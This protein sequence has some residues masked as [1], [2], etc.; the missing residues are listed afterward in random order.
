[1]KLPSKTPKATRGGIVDIWNAFMLVGAS[2]DVHDIP[3]SPTTAKRMPRKLISWPEAKRLHKRA[4]RH[5]DKEY[6]IRAFVHFYVGDVKFDGARSGIWLFPW[7]AYEVIRH[8][9]GIITPDFS[10]CQ[11]FPESLKTLAVYRM[12]TFGYWIGSMG[13]EV[14]NN[15][16]WGTV[17]TWDYC[18]AG[19]ERHTVVSVGTVASGLRERRNRPLFTD[20][21][22]EMVR[23]LKPTAIIVYGSSGCKCFD[24]VSA[25]GIE[26]CQFDS[27]T[28]VAFAKGAGHE[29][30]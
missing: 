18:F 21:L 13:I 16:R 1:V 15:V 14:I 30:G 3:F 25:M 27:E 4:I 10:M 17:E 11:D 12:R 23:R 5:G 8:F 19:I 22:M 24:E 20:G 7:R 28:S 2:Y 26:I 9:D 29:Q 6:H